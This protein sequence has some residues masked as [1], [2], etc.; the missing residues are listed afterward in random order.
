MTFRTRFLVSA[1]A[2]VIALALPQL[3]RA[4]DMP[5][6]EAIEKIVHD[7]LMAHPEVIQEAVTEL[8][9]RQAAAD[10]QK[11]KTA[12]K[13]NANALFSSADQVTLGN[14]N[15]NVTFVEFFDYN[16][17]YCKQAMSDMLTLL[18]DDPNL[19]VVLKEFPVLGEGSGSRA[20]RGRRAHAG[21]NQQEIS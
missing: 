16:C 6:R 1:C 7:Y 11:H 17:G 5:Q 9:K 8:E 12:V 14:P 18:K 4:D 20:R 19:K 21:Q 2:A 13:E 10:A 15:G 3:G